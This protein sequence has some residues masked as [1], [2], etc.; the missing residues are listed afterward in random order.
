MSLFGIQAVD[1]IAELVWFD[2]HDTDN[3]KRKNGYCLDIRTN[4]ELYIV[5]HALIILIKSIEEKAQQHPERTHPQLLKDIKSLQNRL[6]QHGFIDEAL[7]DMSIIYGT[8]KRGAT[9]SAKKQARD[10]SDYVEN[11]LIAVGT[12]TTRAN[13]IRSFIKDAMIVISQDKE[14]YKKDLDT[15]STIFTF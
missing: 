7:E 13:K 8:V 14:P 9:V 15:L 3:S 2:L 4:D 11:E 6:Y 10:I 12:N 1:K 5:C